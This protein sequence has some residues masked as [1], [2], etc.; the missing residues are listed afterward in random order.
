[1][2]IEDFK[3]VKKYLEMTNETNGPV[4]DL[5][6]VSLNKNYFFSFLTNKFVNTVY[7]QRIVYKYISRHKVVLLI[8]AKLNQI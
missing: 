5:C 7:T 8:Q 2:V 1:M 4:M 3:I 6:L